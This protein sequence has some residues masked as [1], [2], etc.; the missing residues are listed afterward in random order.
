[1]NKLPDHPFQGLSK[2]YLLKQAQRLDDMAKETA[3]IASKIRAELTR[4]EE[5][6]AEESIPLII[7]REGTRGAWHA[8]TV[9]GDLVDRDTYRNDLR[10]RLEE[11]GYTVTTI[12][13]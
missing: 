11:Q 2:R 4:R 10:P 3:D 6:S 8:R 13:D 7:K 1:M 12:G 9:E 5:V